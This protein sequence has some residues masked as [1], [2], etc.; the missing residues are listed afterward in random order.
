MTRHQAASSEHEAG[1]H[2]SPHRSPRT[3]RKH[4][5]HGS[6][7]DT[8]PQSPGTEGAGRE[9]AKT[10]PD[11][12]RAEQMAAGADGAEYR[13]PMERAEEVVDRLAERVSQLTSTWGRK[14]LR[15]AARAREEAEDI[16]AEAQSIRRG[17][18][19]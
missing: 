2:K 11:N 16:W 8:T 3:T 10:M 18:H 14:V 1:R 13:T 9:R 7:D 15:W 12:G 5:R 17:E 19:P 4:P 6:A